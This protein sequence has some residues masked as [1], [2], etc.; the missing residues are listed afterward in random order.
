MQ[1]DIQPYERSFS[2]KEAAE[3]AGIASPTVRKYGQILERNGYK[4]SKMVIVVSLFI[5]I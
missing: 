1:F 5:P 2:S 4:F 3:Q